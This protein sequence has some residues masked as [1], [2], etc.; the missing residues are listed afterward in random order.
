[1]VNMKR[2][3]EFLSPRFLS[4]PFLLGL[5]LLLLLPAQCETR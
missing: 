1:L 5:P 3:S 4:A 2:T